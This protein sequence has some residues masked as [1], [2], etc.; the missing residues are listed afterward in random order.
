MWWSELPYSQL[1]QGCGSGMLPAPVNAATH[2]L[3]GWLR[4]GVTVKWRFHPK[5]TLSL[6][7]PHSD[8]VKLA[9]QLLSRV[10]MSQGFVQASCCAHTQSS[11]WAVPCHWAAST[12]VGKFTAAEAPWRGLTIAL[13][14][15]KHS[16]PYMAQ[17]KEDLTAQTLQMVL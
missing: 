11:P 10:Q 13:I 5:F 17:R 15:L 12:A 1:C 4:S 7:Q 3:L 8:M 14:S 6:T 16:C 2:G 9:W